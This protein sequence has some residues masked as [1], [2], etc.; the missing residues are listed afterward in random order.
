MT[1]KAVKVKSL[2]T[3]LRAVEG[4]MPSFQCLSDPYGLEMPQYAI[5]TKTDCTLQFFFHFMHVLKL[6]Y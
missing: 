1:C 6:P 4:Q 5:I 2:V 3:H